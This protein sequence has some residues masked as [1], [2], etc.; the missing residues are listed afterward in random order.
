METPKKKKPS[1]SRGLEF[2]VYSATLLMMSA[3]IRLLR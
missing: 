3:R 2:V 1:I